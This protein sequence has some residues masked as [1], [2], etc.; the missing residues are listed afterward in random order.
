MTKPNLIRLGARLRKLRGE[1]P[2]AEIASRAGISQSYL[3]ALENPDRRPK[4]TRLPHP[5]VAK[6]RSLADAL[7]ASRAELLR[8][9]GHEPEPGLDQQRLDEREVSTLEDAIR[10]LT[11]ELRVFREAFGPPPKSPNGGPKKRSR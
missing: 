6:L 9:G 5:S 11:A 4:G 8:L 7:G 10:E 2:P 1:R 3:W